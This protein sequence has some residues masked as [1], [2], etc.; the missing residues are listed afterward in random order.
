MSES[1]EKVQFK[2][3]KRKN[4]RQRKASSDE[5]T[6]AKEDDTEIQAKL[7]VISETKEKQKLRNRSHGVNMYV[8]NIPGF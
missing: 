7:E 4:I 5:E 2:S 8:N 1:E 3:I 6:P